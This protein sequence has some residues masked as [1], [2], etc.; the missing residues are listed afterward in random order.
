MKPWRGSSTSQNV[1]LRWRERETGELVQDDFADEL[2][3]W[4]E[5]DVAEGGNVGDDVS[6]DTSRVGRGLGWL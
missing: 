2:R 3:S 6:R 4:A 1:S 5:D